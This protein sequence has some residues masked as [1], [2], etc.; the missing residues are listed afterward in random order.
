MTFG[1]AKELAKKKSAAAGPGKTNGESSVEAGQT[2]LDGKKPIVNGTNGF[3]S[4]DA[5]P[6]IVD[7]EDAGDPNDQLAMEIQG[8]R[9][10]SGSAGVNGNGEGSS[11]DVEMH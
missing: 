6:A 7:D 11:R 8:A 4:H 5:A 1:E 2:T 3:G 9:M 10:S